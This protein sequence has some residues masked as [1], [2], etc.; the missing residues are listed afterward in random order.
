MLCVSGS[1]IGPQ[2]LV[3]SVALIVYSDR[4]R[5]RFDSRPV[6]M[7]VGANTFVSTR[8]HDNHAQVNEGG[9]SSIEIERQHK[10]TD[11]D[12]QRCEGRVSG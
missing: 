7:E 6:H 8:R 11:D 5:S 9:T 4:M 3:R 12:N 10:R 2:L 1:K